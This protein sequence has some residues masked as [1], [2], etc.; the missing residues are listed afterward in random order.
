MNKDLTDKLRKCEGLTEE[1]IVTEIFS[2]IAQLSVTGKTQEALQQA[3]KE[4]YSLVQPLQENVERLEDNLEKKSNQLKE[5]WRK[6]MKELYPQRLNL[7][8]QLTQKENEIKRLVVLLEH[9]YKSGERSSCRMAGLTWNDDLEKE[10]D[11]YWQ[12]YKTT[13]SIT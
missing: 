12:E 9:Q 13:N 7:Q 8:Q 11:N 3:A 1:K 6:V 4:I 5:L 2:R 10:L